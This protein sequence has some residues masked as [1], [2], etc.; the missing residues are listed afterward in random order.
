M[1]EPAANPTGHIHFFHLHLRT[2][3]ATLASPAVVAPNLLNVSCLFEKQKEAHTEQRKT[4]ERAEKTPK[5]LAK[6]R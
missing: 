2:K 6:V 5:E 1:T 3:R 4:L